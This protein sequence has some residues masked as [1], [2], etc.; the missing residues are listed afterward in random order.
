MSTPV[1]IAAAACVAAMLALAGATWRLLSG[2]PGAAPPQAVAPSPPVAADPAAPPKQTSSPALA[3][4]APTAQIRPT[5][6]VVRIEPSGEAVVAGRA[7]PGSRVALLLSGRSIADGEASD[8]GQFVI[9]PPR[10]PSGSHVLGLRSTGRQGEVSSEQT[11]AVDVAPR[12]DRAPVAALAAP[13]RPTVVLSAPGAPGSPAAEGAPLR[14]VTVEAHAG[15]AFFVSGQGPSG[16]DVRL[17]LNEAFVASVTVG[18]DGTWSVRVERGM[19]PGAYRVRADMVGSDG[20]PLRRV[21]T[22]FEYPAV[23]AAAGSGAA[24]TPDGPAAQNA[25]VGEMRTTVV[26]RGDTLWRIS[27]SVF[28]EGLRYTEIYDANAA[29]IRDPDLIYP[30][31]VLVVPGAVPPPARR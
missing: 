22:L 10:L 3:P 31:Q 6:D 19:A 20:K 24:K 13:E 4:Q 25:V 8:Q 30:G 9:L 12:A 15:G 21:E 2:D 1:A 16:A 29:Q 23:L 17:Y 7:E 14:I 28:G 11:I 26:S 18:A 5:F 27:R